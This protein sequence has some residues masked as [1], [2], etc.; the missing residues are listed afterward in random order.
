VITF[1][2]F[3]VQGVNLYFWTSFVPVVVI[4]AIGMKLQHVVA[5]LAM[6][7]SGALPFPGPFMGAQLKP[8]DELFWFH[9]P[10]LLLHIIHLVLFQDALE[11]SMFLWQVWQF[12]IRS[13]LV[14]ENKGYFYTRLSLGL[15]IQLFV[16]FITLPLY[17]LVSQMGSSYKKAVVPP[18]VNRVLHVWHKDAKKRLK[19]GDRK[20]SRENLINKVQE[21]GEYENA[22]LSSPMTVAMEEGVESRK[23]NVWDITE[24]PQ[25]LD[26]SIAIVAQNVWE[27]RLRQTESGKTKTLHP[28]QQEMGNARSKHQLEVSPSNTPGSELRRRISPNDAILPVPH[29]LR[30]SS[31]TK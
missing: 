21:P 23:T 5:T 24:E 2:L 9:R 27:R 20:V 10:K 7:S 19:R 6:E 25:P 26:P 11:I 30:S 22:N 4:I 31:I 16:S 28:I 8:G 3:N 15:I 13:C 18:R 12:G 14:E 29:P 1:L 17:A